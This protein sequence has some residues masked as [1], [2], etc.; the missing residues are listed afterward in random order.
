MLSMDRAMD[1]YQLSCT[2]LSSKPT[3]SNLCGQSGVYY[4]SDEAFTYIY[5]GETRH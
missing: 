3:T 2:D 1:E 4:I 5:K